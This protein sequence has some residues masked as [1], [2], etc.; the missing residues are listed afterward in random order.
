MNVGIRSVLYQR[1]R[2]LVVV[3]CQIWGIFF[4]H[5]LGP[6][7][8]LKTRLNIAVYLGIVA[9]H[10]PQFLTTV[11]SSDNTLVRN[12]EDCHTTRLRS[13]MPEIEHCT[14]H[15]CQGRPRVLLGQQV[16]EAGRCRRQ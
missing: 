7:V 10:V 11:H 16:R 4:W 2:V 8:Q 6:T 3:L 9:D 12:I 5:T 13:D 14:G 1:F 15:L